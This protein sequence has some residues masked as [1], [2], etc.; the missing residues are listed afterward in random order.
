MAGIMLRP[1]ASLGSERAPLPCMDP[2]GGRSRSGSGK[3]KHSAES[4]RASPYPPLTRSS[5]GF[6]LKRNASQPLRR[7]TSLHGGDSL[8]ALEQ[9]ANACK[10]NKRRIRPLRA[11]PS[12]VNTHPLD[13]LVCPPPAPPPQC[14]VSAPKLP[15]RRRSSLAPA[16]TAPTAF[17]IPRPSHVPLPSPPAYTCP[18][19]KREPLAQRTIRR[20]FERTTRG[21]QVKVL[22][23]HAAMRMMSE[24]EEE[25]SVAA[26]LVVIKDDSDDDISM[27]DSWV[28]VDRTPEEMDWSI[29]DG[30]Y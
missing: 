18:K 4:V 7:T 28:Q 20:T 16:P 25:A 26:S 14:Q 10:P 2:L 30:D 13:M 22:G 3:V 15:M 19:K 1:L 11:A 24:A 21:A 27:S 17:V 5:G 12:F 23:A 6:G 9:Q 8:A 29:I